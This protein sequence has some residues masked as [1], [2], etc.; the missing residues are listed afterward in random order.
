VY[1][2]PVL[3]I[4]GY[5]HREREEDT[6]FGSVDP[7]RDYPGPCVSG[8]AHRSKATKLLADFTASANINASATLHTY[9]PAVLYPVG[10][11]TNETATPYESTFIQLA[12]VAAADSLYEIG[13]SK[14]ILYAADGA[15][16]D[17][18]YWKHGI[19]SL[20]FEMGSTHSPSPSELQRLIAQNVPGL[21]RF[22][23][24]APQTRAADHAFLGKC[25][26]NVL[27]RARLE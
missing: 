15:F 26:L 5:D 1:I 20:L 8:A 27:Q 3:N 10:F 9:Y 7:N 25:D 16:E 4:S 11:S 14:E 23:E 2:I 12:K 24:M 22:F 19:W 21:R 6:A 13:N 18:A 17:Y